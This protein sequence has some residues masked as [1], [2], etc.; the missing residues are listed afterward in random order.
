[1]VGNWCGTSRVAA[2]ASRH[3]RIRIGLALF[4]GLS[5]AGV[6]AGA[7]WGSARAGGAGIVDAKRGSFAAVI[8]L[9]QPGA[10]ARVA[11][12][13]EQLGG[14]V[15]LRLPI[16]HGLSAR[17]PRAAIAKLRRQPGVVS[18]TPDTRVRAEGATY[19]PGPDVNS[20]ASTTLYTGA[21]DWWNAGYT[22]KGIDVALIDSGVAPVQGLSQPGK[23][24]N[25]PDLSLESQAPNLT[26]VDTYGHGTFMAGLI[27]GRDDSLKA[28]YANAPA[29][30]YRG[31]AP[32]ARIIS[33]KVATADGGTDV[34][35]VIAAID[36]VVQH[37]HDPGLNIRI[38]NLSYGTNS[39]QSYRVDPLADA[40]EQAWKHG[41]VVVAAAGNTGFQRRASAPGLADPAYDPYV[42]AV[43]GSDS[44]GTT[45]T[46]DDQVASYSAS[47]AGGRTR[48]D[49][50]APGSHLQ[51]LRVPG[52]WLDVNH[53]E[54]QL[55]ARYFRGSGTSQAAAITSGA[56]A[57]ILQKY[58]NLTPDLVRD[59]IEGGALTLT[60]YPRSVQGGGEIQL[61]PLLTATPR[62]FLPQVFM[63]S[64][65]N[66]TLEASRG[67]DH[68]TQ[69][70]VELTG[71]QDIFGAPVNTR[72]LAAA[73][74]AGSSWSGG[75]W[76][77]NVWTGSSWSGSSWSGSS[78]SGSSWSGSSWSGSSWSGSSWSGSSWSGGVWSGS[79]WSGSSWS[80]SS[81]SGESW[82]DASWG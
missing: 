31:M 18:V 37:A 13:L 57:L 65:G 75:V 20:M 25:G 40:A 78:W 55:D 74:A 16:V 24:L 71:E 49:F 60:G 26:Y 36:W 44:M 81:W 34:S 54:G 38:L 52:S 8:V 50:V 39:T 21:Q 59:F 28:P 2:A 27:A 35:Q 63:S 46:S 43:G 68:L 79:S 47:A 6:A 1:M 48:P 42:I 76:N 51:G 15:G 70:G 32:D 33:L 11:G 12:E 58:P 29:S 45:T 62:L 67:Q 82:A 69:N 72:S 66:G 14:S 4:L 53:P 19:D 77:G 64:L 80:G 56:I 9:A 5:L 10:E 73:E 61:A 23:V 22:G 7:S 3:A 30:V 41:I 17:L